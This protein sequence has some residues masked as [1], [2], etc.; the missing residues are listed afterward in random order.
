M[1]K[2]CRPEDPRDAV[3]DAYRAIRALS[4]LLADRHHVL[5]GDREL[6]VLVGLVL[7]RLGPAASALQDYVPRP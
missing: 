1:S 4:V 2:T 7:D 3:M 6:P 5:D